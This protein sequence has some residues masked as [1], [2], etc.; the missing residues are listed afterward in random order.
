MRQPSGHGGR[1]GEHHETRRR[2]ALLS[3]VVAAVA[4]VLLAFVVISAEPSTAGGTGVATVTTPISVQSIQ[5][6]WPVGAATVWAWTQNLYGGAAQSLQLSTDGGT[7]WAD[8]TPPDLSE[9]LAG[10]II[11]GFF[12]LD[13]RH[14]WV[15]Y[16]GLT[17]TSVQTIAATSDGGASWSV[18]GRRPS[19]YGCDLQFVSPSDGWCAVVG[20]AAGSAGVTL[21][22]TTDGGHS[23]SIVSESGPN[24]DPPGSLPFGCDKDIAFVSRS[25]GWAMFQCAA[26]LSPLYETTDGGAKWVRR[27]V[28][29]PPNGDGDGSGFTGT[30]VVSGADGAVGYTINGPTPKTFIYVTTDSGRSWKAVTPPGGAQ[31]GLLDVLSPTRWRLVEDGGLLSTDDSGHRWQRIKDNLGVALEYPYESPTPPIV[32]FATGAF[33]WVSSRSAAFPSLWRTSDGGSTWQQV[34]VPGT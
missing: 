32:D 7:Q 15:V 14:A 34:A 5:Q 17:S 3:I 24:S 27:A 8:V 30:P 13:A 1:V 6:A 33:G 21:Y 18:V 29:A 10:H 19:T 4:A 25:V 31:P 16:G 26:G 9:Q 11:D 20:V 2:R 23:W 12:A 28:G 22:R